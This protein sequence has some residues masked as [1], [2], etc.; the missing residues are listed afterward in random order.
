MKS[1]KALAVA[2][3]AALIMGQ[4]RAQTQ[5]CPR[6]AQR[7]DTLFAVPAD[8][9][10][11]RWYK[12]GALVAGQTQN[13]VVMDE[14]ADYAVEVFGVSPAFD[15]APITV[16]LSGRVFDPRLQAVAGAAVR[17]GGQTRFT[18]DQGRFTFESVA[19]TRGRNVVKIEKNGYF[20]AQSAVYFAA[21]D[22]KNT[23]VMLHPKQ[24]PVAFAATQGLLLHNND[25]SIHIPP[26]AV[27][28]AD[29]QAY[30]GPVTMHCAHLSPDYPY[31]G[32]AMPGGD[33]LAVTTTGQTVAL[34]S[35][36]VIG[37]E[38]TDETGAPLNL[39]NGAT[40]RVVMRMPQGLENQ[41]TAALWHFDENNGLWREKTLLRAQGDFLVGDVGHFSW[42]NMDYWGPSGTVRG[43]VVDCAGNPIADAPFCIG[44]SCW[45]TDPNGRFT[46]VRVP[47]GQNLTLT[48]NAQ[49]LVFSL[50][51][52]DTL[53]VGDVFGGSSLIAAGLLAWDDVNQ[54]S[55]TLTV[56]TNGGAPPFE[57]S[58]DSLHWQNENVFTG[59]TANAYSVW[60]REANACVA[61]IETFLQRLGAGCLLAEGQSLDSLPRYTSW[62]SALEAHNQGLPVYRYA[63]CENLGLVA[64]NYV[65]L[66]ELALSDCGLT[67]LPEG[68][69]N[70]VGL[71]ILN[72]SGNPLDTVPSV[73]F[74]L[75]NLQVLD[76]RWTNVPEEDR[77]GYEANLPGVTIYWEAC[78]APDGWSWAKRAGG[79]SVDE[80]WGVASHAD[81][82]ATVTGRFGGTADFGGTTLQSA[83]DY[84]IFV[85]RVCPE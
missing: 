70:L 18:D 79:T 43:R 31:F 9:P 63:S 75:P 78:D 83:G 33:F 53:D 61:R 51:E 64:A 1:R 72:L 56:F 48:S 68:L 46:V 11:Y 81:G 16:K 80:A 37:V 44:Q 59:L 28:R 39:R 4:I 32:F 73:V 12:N 15:L 34:V 69:S 13:F 45:T 5:N 36:G 38:L 30:D 14:N 42:W 84:D 25:F 66:R 76:M 67:Q 22:E 20:S 27:A 60:I 57:F 52:G 2:I 65:C 55:A 71:Q 10:A 74:S 6:I 24:N 41:P 50:N 85:A 26:N 3:T 58:L 8:A 35:Y 23:A 49:T 54:V 7:G 21:G 62:L 77:A 47:A 19:V 17:L 82:S 29:G 40:A